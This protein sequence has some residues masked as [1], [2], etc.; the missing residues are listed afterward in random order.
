MA[1]SELHEFVCE[2]G[3]PHC[4][5]WVELTVEEYEQVHAEPASFVIVDGHEV[6]RIETVVERSERFSVV[7]RMKAARPSTLQN[8]NPTATGEIER[9]C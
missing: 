4:T 6:P 7:A 8:T 3:N 5:E 2:C 1:G 9:R